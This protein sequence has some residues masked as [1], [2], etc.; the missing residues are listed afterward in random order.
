[1]ALVFHWFLP[2][3]GDS[4]YL[5]AGEFAAPGAAVGYRDT[6]VRYLSRIAGAAEQLGF[7]SAL[8]P[9]GYWCDDAWIVT[10]ML[11]QV[12]DRL[13]FLVALRPGLMSP[14]LAAQMV[15]T[16]QQMSKGRLLVNV[17]AGGES[18][19][20]QGYG[21]FLNKDGR[22]GRT[23][24]FL[25]I[26]RALWRGEAVDAE[27]MYLSVRG[28]QLSRLPEPVPDI[29]CAGS[30]AAAGPVAAELADVYLTWAELP[31]QVEEKI[32]W[33]AGLA[34]Q[35]G[36][37]LRFGMRLN[38]ITR[39]TASQA[40]AEAERLINAIDPDVMRAVQ[41]GLSRSESVGQQRLVS[42]H[43]GDMSRLEIYP[44]LWAGVGLARGGA[45]TAFVG[46]HSEVADRI[47]E[48]HQLG[49]EEFIFSGYPHLE[50]VYWFGEGVLPIL[51]KRGLWH[52][53]YEDVS[54]SLSNARF[55]VAGGVPRS[56]DDKA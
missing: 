47:V 37:K 24:E 6:T 23:A 7:V 33:I 5:T 32:A 46:S 51:R 44:N 1:M 34:R 49:I 21:D 11:T 26:V 28:A 15:A 55:T 14:T 52:H 29:Y 30:S 41:E 3:N 17:V 22:Y 19:E 50:E 9:T 12:T 20:A 18:S 42:L 43:K 13:K 25:K 36:R 38:V 27:G 35:C 39:D 8:T 53:P 31:G 2:T 56:S 48:Y 16:F 4:R 45:G 10:A 40:W 54:N